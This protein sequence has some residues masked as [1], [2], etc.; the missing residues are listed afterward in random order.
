MFFH[1]FDVAVVNAYLIWKHSKPA[2]LALRMAD[3]YSLLDFRIDLA[4]QL[5]ELNDTDR[6]LERHIDL[7]GKSVAEVQCTLTRLAEQIERQQ[8]GDILPQGGGRFNS[9][10]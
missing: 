5:A 1:F 2:D 3:N 7:Q 9:L 10:A 6:N 8:L 4:I